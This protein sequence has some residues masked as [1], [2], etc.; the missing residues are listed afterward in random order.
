MGSC[1]RRSGE[2]EGSV[3]QEPPTGGR[4]QSARDPAAGAGGLV[5]AVGVL[6]EGVVGSGGAEASHAGVRCWG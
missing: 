2:N 6:A 5:W 3:G 1:V 4:G